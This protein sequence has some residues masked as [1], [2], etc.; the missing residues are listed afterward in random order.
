MFQ[1]KMIKIG[2]LFDD[3]FFPTKNNKWYKEHA[4]TVF[5]KLIILNQTVFP[6]STE[7]VVKIRVE[8]VRLM[9]HA[10]L[11]P[12]CVQMD[13]STTGYFLIVQVIPSEL[14]RPV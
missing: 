10:T 3:I 13:V 6:V 14:F 1:K 2:T 12:V 11:P 5:F 8:N 4:K 7:K 9:H